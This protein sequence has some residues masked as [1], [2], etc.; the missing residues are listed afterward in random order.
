MALD[1]DKSRRYLRWAVEN[2]KR[3]GSTVDPELKTMF[4]RIA[5][6]YRDL[7][8]Q[9]ENPEQWRAKLIASDKAKQK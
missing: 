6:Q 5:A 8:S 9:I 7:A 1:P 3:A 2:D 4:R